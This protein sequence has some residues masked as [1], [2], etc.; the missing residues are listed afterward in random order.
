MPRLLCG[1]QVSLFRLF[2]DRNEYGASSVKIWKTRH[3]IY[4]IIDMPGYTDIF[5]TLYSIHC[6]EP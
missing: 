4:D 2:T 1:P 5:F 6:S 3:K